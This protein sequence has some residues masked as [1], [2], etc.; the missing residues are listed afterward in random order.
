MF[1]TVYS[2]SPLVSAAADEIFPNIQLDGFSLGDVTIPAVMRAVLYDRLPDGQTAKLVYREVPSS[3]FTG[4]IGSDIVT[5]FS[6]FD[7]KS[8]E[9][10]LF[11]L[12]VSCDTD[13]S[14]SAL[15]RKFEGIPGI[16]GMTPRV[17]L[18][19]GMF[20]PL[21]TSAKVFI[22]R[23]RSC[24]LLFIAG[25]ISSIVSHGI[26]FLMP[27]YFDRFYEHDSSQK[28]QLT[29]FENRLLLQG[30]SADKKLDTFFSAIQEFCERFDFR[31]PQIKAQLAGFEQSCSKYRLNELDRQIEECI[32]KIG[33]VNTKYARLVR[34]KRDFVEQRKSIELGLE[35]VT[36]KDELMN[37][38]LTNKNLVLQSVKDG[39]VTFDVRT[40]LA[41]F[42]SEAVASILQMKDRNS[43]SELYTKGP[44]AVK[45]ADRDVL[46][47]AI[48]IDQTVRVWMYGRFQLGMNGFAGIEAISRVEPAPEM[49]DCCPN[50]HL[51]FYGCMGDNQRYA[52]DALFGGD[53]VAAMEQAIGAAA[54]VNVN[55]SMTTRRWVEHLFSDSYGRF[56]ETEDGQRMNFTE[57]LK[58][59]KEGK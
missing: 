56:F 28:C 50:P 39:T 6:N 26:A 35:G 36:Q 52:T 34:Q 45:C 20:V 17:E 2:S 55:E 19:Q 11:I 12:S 16:F 14:K 9:N 25:H 40:T 58:Y 46:Y 42:D 53:S 3:S 33:D 18:E 23:K 29:E 10:H 4:D 1:A 57:I 41:N 47:R 31:T 38:F 13:D 43:R 48:F 49:H 32:R 24:T 21:R 5:V 44:S 54:S 30:I 59:L 37:Y 8:A 15:M 7:L 51:Y 22:D 27:R